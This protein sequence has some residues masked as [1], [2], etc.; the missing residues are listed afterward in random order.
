VTGVDIQVVKTVRGLETLGRDWNALSARF[1]TP[2]MD[3]DWSLAA[4]C[5]LNDES[6]LRVVVVREDG[7]VSG[8]APTVVDRHLGGRLGVIGASTLHE[9]AGWL[10]ASEQSMTTLVRAVVGLGHVCV[11]HRLAAHS[12]LCR[13]VPRLVRGRGVVVQRPAAPSLAVDAT[14]GALAHHTRLSGRAVR[15]VKSMWTR[16]RRVHQAVSV[17]R[18]RPSAGEVPAL[19]DAFI[20]IEGSGWKRRNGSALSERPDLRAFFAL[21]LAAAAVRG[22]A[23][24]TTL[25]FDAAPAAMELAVQVYGRHWTLKIGYDE[26]LA[27]FGP[28]VLLTDASIQAVFDE[29]LDGYE[30]LGAAE[31]WQTR[32]APDQR[33]YQVTVLYPLTSKAM[34]TVLSDAARFVSRKMH[35]PPRGPVPRMVG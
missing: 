12:D 30:F 24:V 20:T 16:S 19:I 35:I 17:T 33:E 5:A 14:A 23:V 4:A 2:V 27:T 1:A 28:G 15:K 18:L 6:D 10:Y 31:P 8:I 32:W 7:R 22:C 25:W 3:H 26:A 11:L 21:Y 9:P 29:S 13:Q 34:L